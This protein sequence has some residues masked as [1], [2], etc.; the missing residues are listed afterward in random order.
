MSSSR[1]DNLLSLADIARHF[2][3]PES[4]AR[5]YCKRFS[6]FMPIHG[7]GRRRRY[8]KDALAVV[9]MVL[10]HMRA[11][12]TANVIEGILYQHFA[13]TTEPVV[14]VEKVTQDVQ[15]YDPSVGVQSALATQNTHVQQRQD[16]GEFAS[17]AMH[18]LEQQ[19]VA[20]QS[21]AK[22]LEVLASQQEDMHT[23][24]EAAQLAAEENTQ[25]RNEVK[26]LKSLLHSAEQV[27]QDD[28]HQV[29]TWMSR[30]AHS[31]NN[32]TTLDTKKP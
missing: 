1:S 3:L 27:H 22:S 29:R 7:E 8:G 20:M 11:G 17:F 16:S 5:Y 18:L 13:C 12:K 24:R 2:S 21:I 9:A 14:S 6:G 10:E 32:K 30:L 19:N 26:T 15:G 31:Y 28:L 4:T 25:L 23:L